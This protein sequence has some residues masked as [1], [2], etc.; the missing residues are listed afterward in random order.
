MILDTEEKGLILAIGKIIHKMSLEYPNIR[1]QG[2][3]EQCEDHVKKTQE[4]LRKSFH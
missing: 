2:S 3:S 1:W 4:P